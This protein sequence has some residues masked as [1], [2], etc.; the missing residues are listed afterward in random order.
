MAERIFD[1]ERALQFAADLRRRAK[2]L[3]KEVEQ[4]EIDV[5]SPDRTIKVSV[6]VSGKIIDLK[7]DRA[8]D[9][10]G[11]NEIAGAI[12]ATIRSAQKI[13]EEAGEDL[14]RRHLPN[15]PN[16]NDVL[17]RAAREGPAGR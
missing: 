2:Q 7:L 10:R 5:T 17:D 3:E 11:A 12:L 4:T 1:P 8:I 6:T 16:F 15:V 13:A 9:G 14:T